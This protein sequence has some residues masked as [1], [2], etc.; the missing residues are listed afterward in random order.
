MDDSLQQAQIEELHAD[1]LALGDEL[2]SSIDS[3]KAA[4]RPVDLDEP[5]GRLSRVD[6]MQQQKMIQANRDAA[7]GR[8]AQ[9]GAAL[10][11]LEQDEYG[12]CVGCGEAVG[13]ARL[14]A[15][16]EAA[17]CIACQSSRERRA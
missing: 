7:R 1:L 11:R 14:K 17:F 10:A 8:L 15:K 2:R 16:P 4:A 6:A 9:V 13:F 3:S 5:I 12:E